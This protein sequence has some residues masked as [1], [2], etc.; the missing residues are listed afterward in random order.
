[1]D[2]KQAVIK[3]SDAEICIPYDVLVAADGMH[4]HVRKELQI[5]CYCFGKAI[6]IWTALVFKDSTGK[7][8]IS[9]A[10][11]KNGFFALKLTAP[12]ASI[13]CAQSSTIEK[14][15]PKEFEVLVRDCGWEKEA[16][17]MA[18]SKTRI[19]DGI[20]IVLQQA[21]TFSSEKKSV[22]LVGDAAATASFLRGLGLNTAFKTASI[23][24]E[25]F[26]KLKQHNE[27]AFCFFNQKMKE[28][29]DALIEDSQFLFSHE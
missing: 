20:E 29:T 9:P 1:L 25:F 13:I 10:V 28:A 17:M 19:F 8:E 14:I 21:S 6:G 16:E 23:A 26:K 12:Q 3:S 7:F 5:P 22:I 2:Q 4:S 27:D 24:G 18:E 15:S 11:E